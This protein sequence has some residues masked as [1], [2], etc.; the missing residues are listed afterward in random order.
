MIWSN[1]LPLDLVVSYDSESFRN[2]DFD[3][4]TN[5]PVSEHVGAFGVK[6]KHHFH[7][8]VD[9]YAPEGTV[10]RAVEDGVVV[11]VAQFTGEAVDMPWWED[12]WAVMVEGQ[13][14]VVVYGEIVPCS[15]LIGPTPLRTEVCVGDPIGAVKRVLKVDKGRPMSMLHLELRKHGTTDWSGWYE[16]TGRPD[17]LLDPTP[18]LLRTALYTHLGGEQFSYENVSKTFLDR[19]GQGEKS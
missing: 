7:E 3:Y 14:G 1:P 6:R 12:T 9:L 17:N 10:V 16:E 19:Y 15:D 18:H 8:G 5:L 13:S 11:R 2:I 4:K